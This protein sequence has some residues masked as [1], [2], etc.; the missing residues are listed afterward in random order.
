MKPLRP[1]HSSFLISVLRILTFQGSHIHSAEVP[2]IVI[3]GTHSC[4]LFVHCLPFP[5]TTVRLQVSAVSFPPT[6][7][8]ILVL[9]A[10]LR[11]PSTEQVPDFSLRG[12]SPGGASTFLRCLMNPSQL[13]TCKPSFLLRSLSLLAVVTALCSSQARAQEPLEHRWTASGPASLLWWAR[14]ISVWTTAGMSLSAPA[15]TS[16]TASVSL[17][18]SCTT[19]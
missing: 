9:L 3:N 1:P 10:R 17:D 19:A 6:L 4:P 13:K 18:N 11:C 12:P 5:P 16:A 15:T 8:L 2:E 14:S 7:T